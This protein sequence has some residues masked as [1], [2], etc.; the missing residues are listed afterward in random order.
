MGFVY[1]YDYDYEAYIKDLAKE[2]VFW[3]KKAKIG[4]FINKGFVGSI[5]DRNGKKGKCD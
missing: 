3:L 1:Y 2:S 4:I 5:V